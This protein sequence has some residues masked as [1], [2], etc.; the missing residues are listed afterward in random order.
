[1]TR[2]LRLAGQATAVAAVVGLLAL[3]VWKVVDR[4]HSVSAAL[5]G[6]QKPAAPAFDLPRLDGRGRLALASLRGKPVVID[7]WAS[8]CYA[9]PRQTKR[10]MAALPEFPGVVAVGVNTKDFAAAARR[11]VRR[12]R[13]TYPS[14]R[15]RAGEVLT[16]WVGGV[17]LPSMFFV[18]RDGRVV[19]EM[20]V[21]EDLRRY[22]RVISRS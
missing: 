18:D 22:L 1:M 19:G 16:R 4:P 21:E 3:L 14:G 5:D 6:G 13:V 15:D 2:R 20:V 17:R 10:L 9:C 8:W 12:Y 7:F 11:Y